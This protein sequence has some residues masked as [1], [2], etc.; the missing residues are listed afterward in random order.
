MTGA[1]FSQKDINAVVGRVKGAGRTPA[2]LQLTCDMLC[3]GQ[4][5]EGQSCGT[6]V[7]LS[8]LAIFAEG[9]EK[10]HVSQAA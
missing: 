7:A 5:T 9:L 3:E 6:S 4:S 1:G 8:D 10:K 2:A